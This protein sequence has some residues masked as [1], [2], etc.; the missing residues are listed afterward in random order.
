MTTGH[1]DNAG[2][3][4]VG[5]QQKH[6]IAAVRRGV[7]SH[8][9]FLGKDA[10]ERGL[11]YFWNLRRAT[12]FRPHVREFDC[13]AS[14]KPPRAPATTAPGPGRSGA[15]PSRSG[16]TTERLL[17]IDARRR[18]GETLKAIAVSLGITTS[19]VHYHVRLG[20]SPSMR[21]AR[22]ASVADRHA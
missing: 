17:E 2:F 14:G 9:R 8:G 19:A 12:S 18:A 4:R 22:A 16:I 7:D 3:R 21:A 6:S 20:G 5:S 1:R 15:R 11:S 10:V 13:R